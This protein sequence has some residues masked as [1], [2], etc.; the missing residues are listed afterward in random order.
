M[1][2]VTLPPQDLSKSEKRMET[3]TH[4]TKPTIKNHQPDDSHV[5]DTKIF[6]K[7]INCKKKINLRPGCTGHEKLSF[8]RVVSL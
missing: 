2:P 4:R 1:C 7:E 6:W 3:G 8:V 5:S